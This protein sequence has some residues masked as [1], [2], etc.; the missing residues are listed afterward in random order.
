MKT[1]EQWFE[2]LDSVPL[3]TMAICELQLIAYRKFISDVQQ[4]ARADLLAENQELLENLKKAMR[5]LDQENK[6]KCSAIDKCDQLQRELSDER[7]GSKAEA[8]AGDEARVKVKKLQ[9]ELNTLQATLLVKDKCLDFAY[10]NADCPTSILNT[11]FVK[12]LDEARQSNPSNIKDKLVEFKSNLETIRDRGCT[13]CTRYKHNE[14]AICEACIAE[15][16]LTT[17]NET[18]GV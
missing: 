9:Q 16:L 13:C 10:E 11:Q 8:I 5:E 1:P 7:A 14:E 17:L 4:D 15:E 12:L 3:G 6:A 18:F 2:V